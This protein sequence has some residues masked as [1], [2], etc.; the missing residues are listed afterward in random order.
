[1]LSECHL[2]TYVRSA[3][4]SIN[5]TDQLS[6]METWEVTGKPQSSQKLGVEN[7]LALVKQVSNALG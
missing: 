4:K 6:S 3:Y 2:Y 7:P 1:M 5:Q